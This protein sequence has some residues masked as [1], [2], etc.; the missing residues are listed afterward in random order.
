MSDPVPTPETVLAAALELSD[1][2]ERAAC[3]DRACAGNA[4]L[5]QE[6]ES[7]LAAQDAAPASFLKTA[8]RPPSSNPPTTSLL[9]IL[10]APAEEAVGQTLS[11]YKLLE[12]IGEGGCG[13]V[14]VA[15]QREGVKRR[16]A[17]KIIKL[18][19]DTK[20]V[21]ARFEAER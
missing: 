11:R 21:I 16:V 12:K 9:R 13:V 4:A 6:V 3:L 20:N 17:L 2:A 5:P 19:M 10:S 7:L 8:R 1:A 18:G 14:Y 15:E